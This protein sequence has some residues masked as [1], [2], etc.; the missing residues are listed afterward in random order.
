MSR[1]IP[2]IGDRFEVRRP[3][4]RPLTKEIADIYKRF[5]G[6]GKRREWYVSWKRLPKGRYTGIPLEQLRRQGRFIDSA[7]QRKAEQEKR[8]KA[9]E[10]REAALRG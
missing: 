1:L 7:A 2:A 9:I 3:G 8:F 4:R 10:E 6:W 5:M